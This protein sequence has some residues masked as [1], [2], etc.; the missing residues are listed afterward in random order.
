MN[1]EDVADDE[2]F[3]CLLGQIDDL[4]GLGDGVG[5]RLLEEH[6]TAGG[7]RLTGVVGMGVGIGVDRDRIGLRGRESF[8]V[9]R[10]LRVVV[11]EGLEKGLPRLRATGEWWE[12][13]RRTSPWRQPRGQPR[14]S[15][16]R[17]TAVVTSARSFGS[18]ARA[19][20]RIFSTVAT[21]R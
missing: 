1:A 5:Q 7:E 15:P 13:G 4:A 11:A 8:L 17:R 6:V 14:A 9:I 18:A 2:L 21:S 3:S 19:T 12:G 10:E 20:P 16:A